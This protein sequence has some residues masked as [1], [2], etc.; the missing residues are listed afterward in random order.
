[1]NEP[2]RG[3]QTASTGNAVMDEL[4]KSLMTGQTQLQRGQIQLQQQYTQLAQK[5]NIYAQKTD[6]HL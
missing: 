2:P 5:T 4:I 3:Q 1:M 6:T